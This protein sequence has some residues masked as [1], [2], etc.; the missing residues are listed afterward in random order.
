[1]HW[2]TILD[3]LV[4]LKVSLLIVEGLIQLKG[5]FQPK[6]FHGSVLKMWIFSA[7]YF[8]LSIAR[9]DLFWHSWS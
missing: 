6:Q 7:E 1:M 4:W 8:R 5:P 3:N 2:I 9:L